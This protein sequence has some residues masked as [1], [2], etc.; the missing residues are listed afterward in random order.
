VLYFISFFIFPKSKLLS[1]KAIEVE[2]RWKPEQQQ[3]FSE[4]GATAAESVEFPAAVESVATV[5]AFE[6]LC[7]L[8]YMKPNQ[9]L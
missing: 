8:F 5:S 1:D 6:F 7:F 3:L 9:S 2:V 4:T